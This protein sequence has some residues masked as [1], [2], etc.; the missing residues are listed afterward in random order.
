MTGIVQHE[1]IPRN[2]GKGD[3]TPA[4]A[5]MRLLRQPRKPAYLPAMMVRMDTRNMP[6][7]WAQYW[8]VGLD[9]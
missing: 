2:K 8:T 7:E 1:G 4:E 6:G 5:G 3:R 9:S